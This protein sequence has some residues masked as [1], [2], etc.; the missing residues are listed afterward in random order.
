MNFEKWFEEI[1]KD[2]NIFVVLSVR[3]LLSLAF[4][5]GMNY[6]IAEEKKGA[7]EEWKKL[8]MFLKDEIAPVG[9]LEIPEDFDV[10]TIKKEVK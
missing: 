1:R 4:E 9:E 3:G 5:A 6:A 2:T 10:D 7:S 8:N